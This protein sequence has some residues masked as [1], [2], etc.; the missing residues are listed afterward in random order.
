MFKATERPDGR[1][2]DFD[3]ETRRIG[4]HNGGRFNPD[5]CEAIC[6]AWKFLDEDEVNV[7]VQDV[8]WNSMKLRAML[9]EFFEA[10]AE[11]TL[12][13]GHYIRKFDLP[14]LSGMAVEHG[15]RWP[16]SKMT[17]DTKLDL[18][19][20]GGLSQ[21]QENLSAL[22][23]LEASKFPMNDYKWRDAARLTWRGLAEAERRVVADVRQ[24]EELRG[25][26]LSEDTLN[27]PR[28][29]KP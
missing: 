21:S 18:I 27:P 13:T 19:K 23:E 17:S 29:W 4:F 3:I 9:R 15:L 8:A 20:V 6:I 28:M 7:R 26:L 22:L 25:K 24:H 12:V 10:Y 14:I 2:L 1:V 5:G 11:A 16:G